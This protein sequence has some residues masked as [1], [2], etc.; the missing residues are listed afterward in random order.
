MK[1]FFGFITIVV[2]ATIGYSQAPQKPFT[3]TLKAEQI[4][5]EPRDVIFLHII[6]KNTSRH[7]VDCTHYYVGDLDRNYVYDVKYEDGTPAPEISHKFQF[8]TYPC[9][10]QPGKSVESGG[11]VSHYYDMTRPGRYS[12]QVA[13]HLDVTNPSSPVIRSNTITITVPPP[14]Q[15]PAESK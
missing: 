2:T 15:K 4:Q 14:G 3:L 1:F 11:A 5:K 8:D 13:R 12:I 9:S 6:M 7:T 10:L